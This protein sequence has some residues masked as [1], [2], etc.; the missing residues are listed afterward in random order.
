MR[1]R[2]IAG[3][4]HCKPQRS[5][6]PRAQDITGKLRWWQSCKRA[7]I[8]QQHNYANNGLT[9]GFFCWESDST[10]VNLDA[11]V[12]AIGHFCKQKSIAQEVKFAHFHRAPLKEKG[13][14]SG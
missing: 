9:G 10:C 12:D 11:K 8:R 5:Q 6:P 1:A 3:E 7:L 2:D 13:G 14:A 4:L